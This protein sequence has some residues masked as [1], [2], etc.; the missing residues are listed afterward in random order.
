[1]SDRLQRIRQMHDDTLKVLEI[2][3]EMV[4]SSH[5]LVRETLQDLREE[6]RRLDRRIIDLEAQLAELSAPSWQKEG[7]GEQKGV[8]D[9]IT[10]VG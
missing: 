3:T 6:N 7:G 8:D 1:M 4:R 10:A 2:A 5:V 9:T